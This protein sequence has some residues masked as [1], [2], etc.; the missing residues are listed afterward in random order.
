MSVSRS[1]LSN[2]AFNWNFIL[3]STHNSIIAVDKNGFIVIFN[4]AAR[5]TLK[6]IEDVIGR[7]IREII[8]ETRLP[9]VLKTGRPEL[10]K[11][12]M[13]NNTLY[14]T[15][16]TPILRLG[17]VV[18]ALEVF[19]DI[20]YLKNLAD[21][22]CEVPKT[23][24][25]Q[26]DIFLNRI[27]NLK[28]KLAYYQEQLERFSGTKYRL[29]NVAGKSRFVTQIKESI[30]RIASG[31][32][33]VL[34]RGEKGTGKEFLAHIMHSE[35]KRR[36]G[37]FVRI[38]CAALPENIIESEL[39]EKLEIADEG[40]IFLDEI[41]YLSLH[42]QSKLLEV[43]QKKTG[44]GSQN[45]I[46]VRLIA[47]TSR[48][49]EEMVKQNLF[50]EELYYRLNFLTVYIPPLRDRVEDIEP[51]THYFISVFNQDS[52]RKVTGISSEAYSLLL[53]HSWP[54]NIKELEKVLEEAFRNTDESIIKPQHLPQYIRKHEDQKM[55][56]KNSLRSILDDTEK[57][58]LL[59][60]LQATN[61]NKV[62]AAK[63]L[64]ISRA[65][66]YQKLEK[67]NLLNE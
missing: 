63:L 67:Y 37:P 38:E 54:G 62:K 35:S 36:T 34:L 47:T 39:A 29:T 25:L 60:A 12:M 56:D 23:N 64:G 26:L 44:D 48:N 30:K 42:M 59:Q 32:S 40:T 45:G 10:G 3:D 28:A 1:V 55:T 18:G 16:R 8:P 11:K 6:C 7:H 57:A 15:H 66:L 41:G 21:D 53:G 13:L 65:G 17:E 43:M 51:L 61:G 27:N 22:L 50:R 4:A 31:D 46:N 58:A 24:T 20:S 5:R 49:L 52:G 14:L 33:P 9:V 2:W 19:E